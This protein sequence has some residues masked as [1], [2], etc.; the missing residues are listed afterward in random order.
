MKWR[1]EVVR[2]K[3][4]FDIL[5]TSLRKDFF[6]FLKVVEQD[7]N[8]RNEGYER[9]C[10]INADRVQKGKKKLK[11]VNQAELIELQVQ[12]LVQLVF[13]VLEQVEEYVENNPDSDDVNKFID[14]LQKYACEVKDESELWSYWPYENIL[15]FL[16]D[17]RLEEL[18][19]QVLKMLGSREN[20]LGEKL[21]NVFYN[22]LVYCYIR[23][24]C[25]RYCNQEMRAEFGKATPQT[26]GKA[27]VTLKKSRNDMLRTFLKLA[28]EIGEA[29]KAL[30]KSETPEITELEAYIKS[31]QKG[32]NAYSW[33]ELT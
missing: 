1:K 7:G 24:K 27:R 32:K 14:S 30:V 13:V 5:L 23:E 26:L 25:W 15:S 3:R 2:M 20:G 11:Y 19:N 21:K 6:L 31:L 16:S 12:N 28:V 18:Q 4:D 33:C 22:G 17:N 29:A 9:M 8:L 10:S